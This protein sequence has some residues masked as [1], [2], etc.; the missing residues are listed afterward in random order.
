M[1]ISANG[2]GI[3][4]DMRFKRAYQNGTI[5]ET[6]AYKLHEVY[7]PGARHPLVDT[8]GTP[9]LDDDGNQRERVEYVF[10]WLDRVCVNR[11]FAD[12]QGTPLSFSETAERYPGK[13]IGVMHEMMDAIERH[14]NPKLR[15]G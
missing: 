8:E 5:D 7:A 12:E 15:T 10:E 9:V 6:L 11:V 2:D 1:P 4:Q 3:I 14:A 13:W